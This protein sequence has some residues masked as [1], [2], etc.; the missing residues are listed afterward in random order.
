VAI[1]VLEEI[2]KKHDNLKYCIVH[3]SED[4]SDEDREIAD[5][6]RTYHPTIVED[7][8]NGSQMMWLE[9]YHPPGSTVAYDCEFI[10][11]KQSPNDSRVR[12][13]KG[14]IEAIFSRCSTV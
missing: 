8:K 11:E 1:S 4:L 6:F 3:D 10:D 9:G 14:E 5:V 12:K 13:H 7:K 2:A